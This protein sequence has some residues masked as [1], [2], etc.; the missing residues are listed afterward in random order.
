MAIPLELLDQFTRETC[1]TCGSPTERLAA[2]PV[3]VQMEMESNGVED[4]L[5]CTSPA[6]PWWIGIV[7]G[8]FVERKVRAARSGV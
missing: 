3:R 5:K 2:F 6:C 1:P 4:M 8:M 7:H